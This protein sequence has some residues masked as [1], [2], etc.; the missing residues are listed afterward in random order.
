MTTDTPI[1]DAL[2]AAKP[3]LDLYF[4][5]DAKWKLDPTDEQI[6]VVVKWPGEAHEVSSSMDLFTD[7]WVGSPEYTSL[8]FFTY[9]LV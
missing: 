1:V 6:N 2:I 3:I 9:E 5:S 8:V 7:W 4:G